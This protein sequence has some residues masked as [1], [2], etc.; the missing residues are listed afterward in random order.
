MNAVIDLQNAPDD[1]G[2]G[3]KDIE[4]WA[5][6]ALEI[7]GH[8]KDAEITVRLCGREE[9][10]DLNRTYRHVDRPTNILSFPFDGPQHTDPELLGDLVICLPVV[11]EEAREQGKGLEWHF[12]HMVVHGCLHLLGHDHENDEEAEEME[13]LEIEILAQLGFSNPYAKIKTEHA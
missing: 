5:K 3:K 13:N 6:T 4:A 11:Q 12:C 2:I 8:K 7:A 1:L 10:R 9:I